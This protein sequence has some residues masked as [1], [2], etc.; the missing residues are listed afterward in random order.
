M[1]KADLEEL[2]P[3]THKK[4][5]VGRIK[6]KPEKRTSNAHSFKPLTALKKA[7]GVANKRPEVMMKIGKADLRSYSHLIKAA[8]YIARNG[9]LE[10]MDENGDLYEKKDYLSVLYDWKIE[11]G[12][13]EEDKR[14]GFARRIILSMPVGTD[15][16]KFR[17]ACLQWA[18]DMLYGHRYLV[19]F[20][21]A[22]NDKKTHQPHC[23]ILVCTLDKNNKRMRLNREDCRALREHFASCLLAK[24]I[25][26]NAT[27]R[28]SRGKTQKAISQ[29]EIHT[30]KDRARVY[31]IAKKRK[32]LKNQ[33]S[34]QKKVI[35]A[36]RSGRPI[37]DQ[38]GIKIAKK[39]RKKVMELAA[40][41]SDYLEKIDPELASKF[42]D[43][44]KNLDPV[45][46]RDQAMLSQLNEKAQHI[47]R[48]QAMKKRKQTERKS[49][50]EK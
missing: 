25:E 3:E 13:S 23:H 49:G 11:K 28:Y 39:R 30:V 20:H 12:I 26:A 46:S 37:E 7:V 27:S 18:G 42:R 35:E 50:K 4:G 17:D 8:D 48:M 45:Q 5:R 38:P 40:G 1:S 6:N 36:F 10:V 34:H 33:E 41:A 24:G 9:K 47:R 44:Y 16:Q 14:Y 2:F 32:L 15:E 19:S 21:F 29:A 31:A 22:V 43:F